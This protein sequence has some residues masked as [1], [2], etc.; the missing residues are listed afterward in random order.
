MATVFN[1]GFWDGYYLGQ[2]LGEWSNN[3]ITSYNV[4]YTKLL[5]FST[6]GRIHV[7]THFTIDKMIS[8]LEDYLSYN[9][10]TSYNV[11]YTKLLRSIEAYVIND[12]LSK[13]DLPDILIVND[14]TDLSFENA[15]YIHSGTLDGNV[16]ILRVKSAGL[17]FI[18]YTGQQDLRNNFV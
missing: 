4:C 1:R 13:L 14:K 6:E 18:R 10:I 16:F 12:E 17:Y 2:K 11:C 15:K 9:R 7:E 8:N 3:R 5:R